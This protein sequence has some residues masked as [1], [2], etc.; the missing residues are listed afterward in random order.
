MPAKK[1]RRRVTGP[2]TTEQAEHFRQATRAVEAQAA[3]I[4]ARGQAK[5]REQA[6]LTVTVSQ[7]AEGLRAA[8]LKKGLSAAEVARRL[9]MDAGNYSKLE[10]GQG[11]PT[12]STLSRIAAAIGVKVVVSVQD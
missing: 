10:G 12:L 5:L 9:Q 11:N 8:R 2:L 6:A 7:L 4:K 3:T 1:I